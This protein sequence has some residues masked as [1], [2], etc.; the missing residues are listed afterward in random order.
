MILL[1]PFNRFS[2]SALEIIAA[3]E[4][5]FSISSMDVSSSGFS[6]RQLHAI[7]IARHVDRRGG[8]NFSNKRC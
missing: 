5:V 2:C 8:V 1:V 7:A 3:D 4:P 6:Y